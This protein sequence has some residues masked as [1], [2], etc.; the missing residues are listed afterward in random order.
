MK[1]GYGRYCDRCGVELTAKNNKCGYEICD[2][3]NQELEKECRRMKERK[4]DL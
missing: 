4:N 3:C 2:K 1:D